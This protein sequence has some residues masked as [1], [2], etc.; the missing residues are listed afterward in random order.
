[1]T[2]LEKF[3]FLNVVLALISL[4]IY[5]YGYFDR[6]FIVVSSNIVFP[7][8]TLLPTFSAYLAM[9]KY[10]LGSITGYA[11]FAF[12]LGL[13]FW[14]VG[15][16]V[17]AIYV[18]AYAIEVP[19]PSI[20]DIFYLLGYPLFYFGLISY[21]KVFRDAL[22]KKVVTISSLAGLI[23]VIVTGIFVVPE[24]LFSTA[25]PIEGLISITYPI[26]DAILI[27]LAIMGTLIFIGGRIWVSWILLSI[28]FIL[29]GI[30]DLSYY[31]Q[32]LLGLIWEGHPLELI[33]LWSYLHLAVALYNHTRQI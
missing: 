25:N 11:M 19:F 23:V 17:W 6:E 30:V 32:V 14:F 33:Y 10:G 18:L 1:M 20:A 16:V 31:Y 4:I 12:F 29:L 28:G 27:I 8:Y 22:N 7:I 15:E 24:A 2:R 9:K 5:L 3:H 21:L 13:F 26:F